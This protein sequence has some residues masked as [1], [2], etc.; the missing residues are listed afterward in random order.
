MLYRV[1]WKI[2]ASKTK[3]PPAQAC[4]SLSSLQDATSSSISC[5]LRTCNQLLISTYFSIVAPPHRP[6]TPARKGE[7]THGSHWFSWKFPFGSVQTVTSARTFKPC[8]HDL[9]KC[10]VMANFL[11]TGRPSSTPDQSTVCLFT[12]SSHNFSNICLV[13]RYPSIYSPEAKH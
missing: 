5:L 13:P 1:T 8:V 3:K 6:H 7:E 4:L 2:S 10:L 9:S 11:S 12:F